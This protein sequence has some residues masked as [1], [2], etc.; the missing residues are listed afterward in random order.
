MSE[1]NTLAAQRRRARHYALQALYQWTMAGSELADIEAEF[2]VD[3]DFRNVDGDYF[4][5]I[6]Q[7]V[8]RQVSELEALFGGLL[9]R[10]LDELDPIE[11]TL[12]RMGTF[13]LRDR[14]DVP[15]R[16]VI[17]EYVALAKKFGA[18]ESFRYVNGIL[19]KVA[20]QLRAIEIAAE[21]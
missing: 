15:Y 13:E 19:D 9:D 11:R 7:G 1:V 12:L 16:V 8:T 10:G 14:I 18:S 3:Y 17:N 2:R 21:N 4:T 20:K 5:A 6:L